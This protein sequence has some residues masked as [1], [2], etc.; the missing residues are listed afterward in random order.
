MKRIGIIQPGR[1]GDIIISLPIAKHYADLGYNVVWP[2]AAPF[3]EPFT[4][5]VDYVQFIPIRHENALDIGNWHKDAEWILKQFDCEKVLDMLYDFPGSS[6]VS[7]LWHQSKQNFDEYRYT[8]SGIPFEEKWNLSINRN[9]KRELDLYDKL[10]TQ[11]KYIVTHL[12]SSAGTK[13]VTLS[14][15]ILN[16]YQIINISPITNNIF[17]W[18]TILEK[19]AKLILVDSC[20][21]NLVEQLDLNDNKVLIPKGGTYQVPIVKTKWKV[22]NI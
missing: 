21:V 20:F 11:D 5:A 2:I 10:V 9:E 17:D 15:E 6:V 22:M 14:D 19:A 3:I 18:C 12:T 13:S 4:D 8:S 7:H 1:I 16:D